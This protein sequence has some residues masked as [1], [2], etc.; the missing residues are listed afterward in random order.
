MASGIQPEVNQRNTLIQ[1]AAAWAKVGDREA[2]LQIVNS[3]GIWKE[4]A[5]QTVARAQAQVGDVKGALQTV[6][7]LRMDPTK[8]QALAAIALVQAN[9]GDRDGARGT[10]KEAQQLARTMPKPRLPRGVARDTVVMGSDLVWEQLAIAQARVR[11]IDGALQAAG[12]LDPPRLKVHALTEIATAQAEGGDVMSALRTF[13]QARQT[14]DSL[15]ASRNP[16]DPDQ[17]K[18]VALWRIALARAKIGDIPGALQTVEAIREANWKWRTLREIAALRARR[19]DVEGARQMAETIGH[20]TSKAFALREIAQAQAEAGDAQG[21]LTWLAKQD[22]PYFKAQI[23]LG[24]TEGL[25][26][27]KRPAK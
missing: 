7:E 16:R 20:Q 18:H 2:A 9:A 26:K 22:A 24:L 11:D 8:A 21:V 10:L 25:A 19:G 6:Q 12:N 4:H 14:V 17:D 5:L 3:L 23:L 13:G 1:I 15:P 27:P